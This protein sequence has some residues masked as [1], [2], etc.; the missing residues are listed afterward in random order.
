MNN[1]LKCLA[2][3]ALSTLFLTSK[4]SGQTHLKV[5]ALYTAALLPNISIETKLNPKFTLE[6]EIFGSPWK[7]INDKPYLMVGVLTGA[8]YYINESFDGFYVGAYVSGNK[9]KVS[10][11][12]YTANSVQRGWGMCVGGTVGYQ[13]AISPKCNMDFYVGGGFH[14]AWYWGEIVSTGKEYVG[15]NKSAEWL[16][17]RAG[18]SFAFKN[19]FNKKRRK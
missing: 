12:N 1:T 5:N 4:A 8:R 15:W 3:F 17:Y 14:H 2:I 7:S 10:K 19:V 9:F 13:L 6:A 18:V 16:P 11:W